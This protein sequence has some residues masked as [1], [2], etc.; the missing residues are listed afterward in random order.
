LAIIDVRCRRL[1]HA[2]TGL[3]WAAAISSFG[4]DAVITKESEG[5]VRAAVAATTVAGLFLLLALALPGQLGLGDVNLVGVLA[6]T[7]GWI[8]SRAVVT[9]LA[10]GIV[11]Q[12]VV[13]F[14]AIAV[15]RKT[16]L[17]L[18]MGPALL[19]GWLLAVCLP[20]YA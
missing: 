11:I 10:A 4:V 6:L 2:L 17:Q 19:I 5:L 12:A 20:P 18:A 3:L 9:G 16:R 1:P 7:L 15:V 8:G 14:A 13:G